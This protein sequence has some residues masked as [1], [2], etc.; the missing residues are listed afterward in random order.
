MAAEAHVPSLQS[1]TSEQGLH[2]QLKVEVNR[3]REGVQAVRQRWNALSFGPTNTPPGLPFKRPLR[4]EAGKRCSPEL[5]WGSF[6]LLSLDV[7]DTCLRRLTGVPVTIFRM[8]EREWSLREGRYSGFALERQ[9]AEKRAR[10]RVFAEGEREDIELDVIYDE[11]AEVYGW[12]LEE[13]IARMEREIALEVAILQPERV[14]ADLVEEAQRRNCPVIYISDMYLPAETLAGI[15]R[16]KGFAVAEGS[17]FTSGTSRLTKGSGAMFRHVLEAFPGK[18]ICHIGDHPLSDQEVPRRMGLAC[19][20]WIPAPRFSEDGL[21]E[22]M[23]GLASSVQGVDFWT[24]IGYTVT[25]PLV[26][27]WMLDL[28]RRLESD[29][30]DALAFLTRDG[31]FPEKA[32][33]AFASELGLPQQGFT[34]YG[35]RATLGLSSM[36]EIE[37]TDWDFLLKPAPGMEVRDF[38]L[39]AGVPESS[40]QPVCHRFGIDPHERVC[41]HRGF[42][43]PAFKDRLYNVFL[44]LMD[45]VYAHRDALRERV[46][47]YLRGKGFGEKRIGIV[48][49]G[50]NG[51]SLACL[52][53]LFPGKDSLA[54]YYWA[55]WPERQAALQPNCVSHFISGPAAAAEEHLV[56]GGTGLL[57]FLL[58][59]PF[60]SVVDLGKREDI[61]L[62]VYLNPEGLGAFMRTAYE[63]VEAGFDA[64]ILDFLAAG[65]LYAEGNGRDFLHPR[66]EKLV[67]SPDREERSRLGRLSHTEGWGLHR[68]LTLLPSMDDLKD[69]GQRDLAYAYSAWKG[70]WSTG[71]MT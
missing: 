41:H 36:T 1:V 31:Y 64:F 70:A 44:E 14:M 7:F 38:F 27:A 63:K 3:L 39:R 30:V 15:L 65:G 6:D 50:W 21:S 29:R 58:G 24:R 67:F 71:K 16:Q 48:D 18:R 8:L 13:R 37:A 25:G 17:V 40:F 11:L 10:D 54:G 33:A 12:S 46:L 9:E 53:R 22:L 42:H 45:E 2:E 4:V 35:S 66:L 49:T 43:D 5:D 23:Y 32:F 34:C 59:S 51:S 62:P 28:A 69:P 68:P 20:G 61:W 47:D 26:A 56:R 55:L 60:P 57:E 52:R 19:P